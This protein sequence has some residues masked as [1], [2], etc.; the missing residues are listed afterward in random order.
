MVCIIIASRTGL[1]DLITPPEHKAVLIS[2]FI[3]V[4]FY[5]VVYLVMEIHEEIKDE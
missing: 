4:I 5:F 1:L 3:A 2:F